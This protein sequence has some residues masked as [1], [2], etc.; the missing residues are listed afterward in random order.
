MSVKFHRYHTKPIFMP[1]ICF[2]VI[3]LTTF[4]FLYIR[5]KPT[6]LDYASAAL[7]Q[8]AY[9]AANEVLQTTLS[10]ENLSYEDL[11][12]H[13]KNGSGEIRTIQTDAAK[14]NRIKTKTLMLL[15]Q[16]LRSQDPDIIQVPIGNLTGN[17]FLAGRGPKIPIKLL[18]VTT[19]EAEYRN[20]FSDAGINQTRHE[21]IMHIIIHTG[22]LYP[23]KTATKHIELDL[24]LV[25][26]IIIGN[27]PQFYAGIE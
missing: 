14:L 23:S 15:L 22:M 5:I 10:S 3:L 16:I 9:Y 18:P 19:I 26:T 11:V 17:L 4:V 2:S 8:K 7:Y 13:V 12:I 25:E 20:Q 1:Y 6:L 27:V 24:C 21:I